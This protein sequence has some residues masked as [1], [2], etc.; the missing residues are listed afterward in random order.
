MSLHTLYIAEILKIPIS[1]A[2]IPSDLRHATYCICGAQMVQG[3]IQQG[4]CKCNNL[5]CQQVLTGR[6]CYYCPR[7]SSVQRHKSGFF[8]CTKC[9]SQ[10]ARGAQ[11]IQAKPAVIQTVQHQPKPAV[12]KSNPSYPAAKPKGGAYV[13]K[14]GYMEKKGNWLNTAYKKRWFKLWRYCTLFYVCHVVTCF[15]LLVSSKFSCLKTLENGYFFR[16]H[17]HLT[18]VVLVSTSDSL[19]LVLN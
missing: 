9:A 19:Y 18:H 5:N 3:R 15:D 1:R 10:L 12:V 8:Y 4:V 17:V 7:G 2:C 14:Q 11:V 13:V 6:L 16:D